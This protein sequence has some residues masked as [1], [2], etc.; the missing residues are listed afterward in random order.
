MSRLPER[1]RRAQAAKGGR[2]GWRPGN[3]TIAI[4]FILLFTIGPY[5]AF[6]QHV[7]V[8]R[9]GYEVKATFP[10]SANIATNSPVR[11]A[12]VDVGKVISTSR[13]GDNTTATF[14]VDGS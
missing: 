11:V 2:F 1:D 13:D 6:T 8:S 12:G 3:V 9:H 4:L 14:T 5:L 7:P 10:N